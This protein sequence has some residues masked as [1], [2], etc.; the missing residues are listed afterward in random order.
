MLRPAAI[1][2]LRGLTLIEILVV[3]ALWGLMTALVTQ[4]L[5]VLIRS[6]RQQ[7]SRSDAHARVQTSLAQWQTDL[8]QLDMDSGISTV[9]DWNGQVLR[10]V[11]FSP[12]PQAGQRTVVAWSML[13]GR[14]VRWQSAPISTGAELAVAWQAA[15]LAAADPQTQAVDWVPIQGW[16]LFFFFQDS[17]SNALSSTGSSPTPAGGN[18]VTGTAPQSGAVLLPDAIRLQL[19]L[20]PQNGLQGR[21][22]WDWVRPTWSVNRS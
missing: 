17:W 14:W 9:L 6:Q 18:P 21:L 20:S 3:L 11:R 4:G 2:R 7:V 12:P 8:T 5:D 10:L 13:N 16:Q 15:L 19:D 1:S 22:Q